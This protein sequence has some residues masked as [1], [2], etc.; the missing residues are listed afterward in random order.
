SKTGKT[1]DKASEKVSEAADKVT[2]KLA[3]LADAIRS[4]AEYTSSLS[5]GAPLMSEGRAFVERT[6]I[7]EESAFWQAIVAFV[8]SWAVRDTPAE[9]ESKRVVRHLF[10][11]FIGEESGDGLQRAPAT[12]TVRRGDDSISCVTVDS[13]FVDV[14]RRWL[15]DIQTGV[16]KGTRAADEG[17]RR[18]Y[19]VRAITTLLPTEFAL[20]SFWWPENE[21]TGIGPSR[22]GTLRAFVDQVVG[23]CRGKA[24]TGIV[25]YE[26]LTILAD[27]GVPL[28]SLPGAKRLDGAE[29]RGTSADGKTLTSAELDISLGNW[30]LWDGRL[31]KSGAR[32]APAS[33]NAMTAWL[34]EIFRAAGRPE[35]E[36]ATRDLSWRSVAGLATAAG[37]PEGKRPPNNQLPVLGCELALFA[38]E[39]EGNDL[40][41]GTAFISTT[42]QQNLDVLKNI[43]RLPPPGEDAS[44]WEDNV[45]GATLK[46]ALEHAGWLSLGDWYGQ[47]MHRSSRRG[48]GARWLRLKGDKL[49]EQPQLLGPLRMEWDHSSWPTLELL[50]IGRRDGPEAYTWLGAALSDLNLDS[51]ACVVKIITG[52][53]ALKA[54]YDTFAALW[55]TSEDANCGGSWIEPFQAPATD[56]DQSGE[57][58]SAPIGAPEA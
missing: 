8:R 52:S 41:I 56:E 10:E 54:L 35:P 53:A 45:N 47:A 17:Q 28:D 32:A 30:F 26:R 58:I 2:E 15:G 55:K 25:E 49:V 44:Q 22:G 13:V 46:E 7:E 20:P 40:Q 51:P 39:K 36:Y 48:G 5:N 23:H 18:D 31:R 27:S 50:L 11:A 24:E 57:T 9:P 29:A 4:L 33:P 6:G 14:S 38:P 37:T 19:V 3:P 1:L 34:G 21:L 12:G 16:G 42:L 43:G